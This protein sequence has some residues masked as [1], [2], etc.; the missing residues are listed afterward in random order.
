MCAL[1]KVGTFLRGKKARRG[2]S[3]R[4]FKAQVDEDF[5]YKQSNLADFNLKTLSF[6]SLWLRASSYGARSTGL[7]RFPRSL[8]A[9]LF[10]VKNIDVFI[11]EAGMTRLQ[12]SRFLR[13]KWHNFGLVCISILGVYELALLVKLQESTKLW[14]PRKIQGYC[15]TILVEFLEFIL[16][17]RGKITHMNT[18]QNS[19]Q[20]SYRAHM[21][22]PGKSGTKYPLSKLYYTCG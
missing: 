12:R 15:S 20:P 8:L 6:Q 5:D 16:I 17:N 13:P 2:S 10:F 18:P 4:V 1:T 14:Q 11:W 9:T 21:K 3:G 22:R 7:A 19:S